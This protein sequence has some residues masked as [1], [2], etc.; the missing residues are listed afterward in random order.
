MVRKFLYFIAGAIV[1]VMLALFLLRIYAEELTEMAFV[2][3]AEF[4][5]QPDLVENLYADPAMWI[6]RPG[7]GVKDPVLWHPEGLAEEDGKALG[8]AVFFIHPTSY[9][10]RERWN[11]A[12]DEPVSRQRAELFVKGMASPFNR[13]ADIWAPRYRQ[14]AFGAFLVDKPEAVRALDAAYGDVLRAFDFFIATV[15]KD[16]PIV[17]AGHSQGA[18]HLR[19]LIGERIANTPLEDRVAAAYVIGWPVSLVHDLP[20]MRL[21][22]CTAPDQAGCVMSWLSVAEPADNSM[23]LNNYAHRVGLDGQKLSD[24]AFLCSNPLTGTADGEADASANLGTLVP[25]IELGTGELVAGKVA[26]RCGEDGFLAIGAPPVLDL[27]P[28][29]LPGNNYHL[30]D[31]V[32]FWANLRADVSRRVEAWK[33]AH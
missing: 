17:L 27:G 18:F 12:V 4:T 20:L 6:S 3:T 9:L 28:Y 5:P 7:L 14:A 30:Y 19:R 29:V 24:S 2:P 31:I 26:A 21:L 25:D 11:A 1:L 10:D 8:A 23:L 13:S 15:A 33:A 16:R 22:P 32:L